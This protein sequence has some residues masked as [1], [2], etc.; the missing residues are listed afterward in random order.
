MR[1]KTILLD[2]DVLDVLSKSYVITNGLNNFL[3][4]L[5]DQLDRKLY[6]RVNKVLEILGGKWNRKF[7]SHVFS[8]DP[9]EKIESALQSETVA[10]VLDGYF[11]TPFTVVKQMLDLVSK[12]ILFPILEPS[13]GTGDLVNHAS[14]ILNLPKSVFECFE[15]NDERRQYLIENEYKVVG[16]DFFALFIGKKY[17]T[18]LMNP[19]FEGSADINH[20]MHAYDNYLALGGQLVSV[21]SEGP[22][23]REDKRSKEFRSFLQQANATVVKLP[24][25]SFQ[26]SGTNVNTRLVYIYH[27]I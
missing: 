13:A 19:P 8:S 1:T 23:F 3:L 4:T 16:S 15:I 25:K 22:F 18:I 20:I 17:Q 6:V 11:I 10:K 7:G 21:V 26:E 9:R 27:Q 12:H 24:P 2:N 14:A 5:P